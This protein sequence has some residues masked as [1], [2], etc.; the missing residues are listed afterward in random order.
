MSHRDRLVRLATS[1]LIAASLLIVV[2]ACTSW[3]RGRRVAERFHVEDGRGH[4]LRLSSHPNRIWLEYGSVRK[5]QATRACAYYEHAR[6]GAPQPGISA[7]MLADLAARYPG[8]S[9]SIGPAQPPPPPAHTYWGLA[10][11]RTATHVRVSVPTWWLLSF[12]LPPA[13][14]LTRWARSRRHRHAGFCHTCGYDLR[15]SPDRC[16]ECGTASPS[17]P[18]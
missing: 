11:E 15:A 12:A 18:A 1:T 8:R 14:R 9:F 5:A 16:P 13:I 7:R 17:I 6:W 10:A 2:A 3:Y 4:S